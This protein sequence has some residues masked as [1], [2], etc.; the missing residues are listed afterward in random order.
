[1]INGLQ[2]AQ[3]KITAS[4]HFTLHIHC[5]S[6]KSINQTEVNR[7]VAMIKT[8]LELMLVNNRVNNF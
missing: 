7:D 8:I 4:P 2:G 5:T 3:S 6:W 1:M